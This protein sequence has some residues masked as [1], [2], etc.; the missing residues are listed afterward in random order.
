M[1][2]FSAGKCPNDALIIWNTPNGFFTTFSG[3]DDYLTNVVSRCFFGCSGSVFS[4][5]RIRSIK[6]FTRS[7]AFLIAARKS[8]TWDIR[9]SYR[10]FQIR[11]SFL[12]LDS[13]CF[14]SAMVASAEMPFFARSFS[15][16][17]SLGVSSSF[18]VNVFLPMLSISEK[19]AATVC[20]VG[21]A[22]L[23]SK[24]PHLIL[25]TD[26]ISGIDLRQLSLPEIG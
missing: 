18:P 17:P 26:N 14:R 1:G 20:R 16:S 24:I 6:A 10:S 4:V 8:L 15:L 23:V 7:G 21:I 9:T 2:V 3:Q 5:S 12:A 13:L 11:A 25:P 22:L 19:V